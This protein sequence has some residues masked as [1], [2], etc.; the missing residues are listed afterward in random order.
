MMGL[1]VTR[2]VIRLEPIASAPTSD[3][4]AWIGPTVQRY[5]TADSPNGGSKG[6]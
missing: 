6:P 5:L 2:Y 4:V 3:L 1:A